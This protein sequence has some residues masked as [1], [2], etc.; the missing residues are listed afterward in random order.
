MQAELAL[1]PAAAARLA[2]TAQQC[3][4]HSVAVAVAEHHLQLLHFAALVALVADQAQAI[5]V[6]GLPQMA[7]TQLTQLQER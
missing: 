6:Q 3:H 2:L 4:T 5:L 1:G 7:L